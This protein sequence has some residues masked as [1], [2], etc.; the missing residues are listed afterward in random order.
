MEHHAFY[1]QAV[2]LFSLGM[3]D[4]AKES[5]ER[6]HVLGSQKQY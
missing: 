2:A 5:I 6:W 1:L 4:D 3:D